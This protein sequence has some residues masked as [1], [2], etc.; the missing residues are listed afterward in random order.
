MS[1]KS[2]QYTTDRE[3]AIAVNNLLIAMENWSRIAPG[4]QAD[5]RRYYAFSKQ[6]GEYMKELAT[7]LQVHGERSAIPVQVIPTAELAHAA[8]LAGALIILSDSDFVREGGTGGMWL[9][10]MMKDIGELKVKS[11]EELEVVKQ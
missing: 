7:E 3:V 10:T 6:L 4:R 8:V 5:G 1:I 11:L 9:S 2:S